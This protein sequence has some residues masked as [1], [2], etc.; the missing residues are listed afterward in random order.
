MKEQERDNLISLLSKGELGE[1]LKQMPV[2]P[3]LEEKLKVTASFSTRLTRLI[4]EKSLAQVQKPI[5]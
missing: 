1:A 3:I 4:Q 2:M 5:G